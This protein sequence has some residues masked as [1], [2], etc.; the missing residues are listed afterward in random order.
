MMSSRGCWRQEKATCRF[1]GLNGSTM[2]YRTKSPAR[3][4]E[5]L[6][7]LGRRHRSLAFT[8]ADN[9]LSPDFLQSIFAPLAAPDSDYRR[10]YEIKAS[11]GREELAADAQRRRSGP[12]TG[13][14]IA[15]YAV[16]AALM[17]KGTRASQNVN[18]VRW[19]RYYGSELYSNVLLGFP[20]ETQEDYAVRGRLARTLVHLEPPGGSVRIG[21]ESFSPY[22]EDP[23]RFPVRGGP[24]RPEPGYTYTYPAR[25]DLDRAAYHLAGELEGTL[26]DAA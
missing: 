5:E 16:V 8:A 6:Q 7:V 20:G 23:E 22:F 4:L 10:F 3:V 26:G 14:R 25:V 21:L 12:A 15:Q 11:V 13:H 17:R 18:F 24:A 1:C 2:A 9:I 19:A